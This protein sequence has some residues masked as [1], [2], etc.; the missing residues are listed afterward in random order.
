MLEKYITYRWFA[1][2]IIPAVIVGG[3]LLICVGILIVGVIKATIDKAIKRKREK[4]N[5]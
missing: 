3:W 5:D 4:F 1:D 2:F